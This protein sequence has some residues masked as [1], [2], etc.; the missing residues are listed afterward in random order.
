MGDVEL[1]PRIVGPLIA[2]HAE[3]WALQPVTGWLVVVEHAKRHQHGVPQERQAASGAQHP[4]RLG[5]PPVRITPD[6]RSVLGDRKVEALV[7]ERQP[8]RVAMN[9]RKPQVELFLETRRSRQLRR[10]VVDPDRLSTPSR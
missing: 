10:R 2:M 6:G 8:L 9:E 1:D 7:G 5:K 4:R 3:L